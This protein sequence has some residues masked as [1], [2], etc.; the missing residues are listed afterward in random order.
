MAVAAGEAHTCVLRSDGSLVTMGRVT[1]GRS[2]E[3]VSIE[4]VQEQLKLALSLQ[5]H[6]DWAHFPA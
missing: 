4:S 3:G 6:E 1:H 2:A 5:S